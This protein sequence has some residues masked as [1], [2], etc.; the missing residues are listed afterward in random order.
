M[1]F[2][3]IL[4][5]LAVAGLFALERNCA[6]RPRARAV[7]RCL[8]IATLVFSI[9]FNLLASCERYAL[10]DGYAGQALSHLN[11]LPDAIAALRAALRM[12]PGDSNNHEDLGIALARSGEIPEAAAE[13]R[14]ALQGDPGRADAHDNL[15]N[16]LVQMGKSP[17]AIAEFR[18]ALRL[19]PE[20]AATHYNLAVAL[21]L[22]GRPAEAADE[23]REAI[24]LNPGLSPPTP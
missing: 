2:L 3:P 19:R 22:A 13:F 16:A 21:Q 20:S 9:A 4:V 15:G 5:L 23:Y 11:R 24:R 1:E 7:L 17:E 12:D 18:E 10:E 6:G 8:W 14:A